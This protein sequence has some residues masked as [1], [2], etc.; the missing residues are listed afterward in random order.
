MTLYVKI[1][2]EPHEIFQNITLIGLNNVFYDIFG[3]KITQNGQNWSFCQK[4]Q[5]SVFLTENDVIRLKF[6]WYD[7]IFFQ[8][9]SLVRE[10]RQGI[11]IKSDSLT[12]TQSPSLL[13]LV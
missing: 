7:K 8:T 5:K 10:S 11:D 6:T 9:M 1:N 4:T 12:A 3:L 2:M 13:I